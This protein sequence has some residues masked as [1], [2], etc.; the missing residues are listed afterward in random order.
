MAALK[1]PGQNLPGPQGVPQGQPAPIN[2][3]LQ[4]Q[5]GPFMPMPS[6]PGSSLA[7]PQQSPPQ[8][9][10]DMGAQMGPDLVKM[11]RSLGIRHG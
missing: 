6:T 10:N 5:P 1:K 8:Y 7:M 2:I 11:L 9:G 4:G 3:P